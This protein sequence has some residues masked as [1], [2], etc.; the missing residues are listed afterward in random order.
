MQS[1]LP[2][3]RAAFNAPAISAAPAAFVVLVRRGAGAAA[4][5]AL[6]GDHRG[7]LAGARRHAAVACQA[8]ADRFAVLATA[9]VL[10]SAGAERFRC[11][12]A[13]PVVGAL[14]IEGGAPCL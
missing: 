10:D 8:V 4:E 9:V 13:A 6:R 3:R 7:D 1:V 14:G 12:S 2:V 11:A 5:L